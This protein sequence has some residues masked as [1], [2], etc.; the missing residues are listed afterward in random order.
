[1]ELIVHILTFVLPRGSFH[2][3]LNFSTTARNNYSLQRV[4]RE[5][6]RI[7]FTK[8]LRS[9]INE[10]FQ[11]TN[12]N[13]YTRLAIHSDVNAMR[14]MLEGTTSQTFPG[15]STF[16]LYVAVSPSQK[17]CSLLRDIKLSNQP[18]VTAEG[19]L[20]LFMNCSNV[21]RIDI[22]RCINFSSFTLMGLIT[23]LE[24]KGVHIKSNQL[25][26]LNIS[27]SLADRI[28]S[29][30]TTFGICGGDTS[31][32]SQYAGIREYLESLRYFLQL[33]LLCDKEFV[34][35][36]MPCQCDGSEAGHR[37]DCNNCGRRYRDKC[38]NGTRKRFRPCL[39][40][41]SCSICLMAMCEECVSK[42]LELCEVCLKL[43]CESCAIDHGLWATCRNCN[44]RSCVERSVCEICDYAFCIDCESHT[45]CGGDGCDSRVCISCKGIYT[46]QVCS[47]WSCGNC[48]FYTDT[49]CQCKSTTC[50]DCKPSHYCDTCE[51]FTCEDCTTFTHCENCSYHQCSKCGP[52][53]LCLSCGEETTQ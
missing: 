47:K 1:M 43:I 7:K 16:P 50:Q 9:D 26:C 12:V 10:F 38:R 35:Y 20:P 8:T 31:D 17:V 22:T 40:N 48:D 34:L 11:L 23:Q 45:C 52:M 6:S 46:C 49:C 19:V 36:P 32:L 53:T 15:T 39:T 25:Q 42:Y 37:S 29:I 41:N 3:R 51:A 4:E 2:D 5:D 44:G 24:E 21:T 27:N 13:S 33:G 28:E 30:S 14:A 18:Q